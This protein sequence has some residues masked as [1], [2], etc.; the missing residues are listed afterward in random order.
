MAN[1]RDLR[2]RITSVGNIEK[3]T[4]AMEMVATTK[5]RRFQDKAV[6]AKPYTG[7]IEDLVRRLAGAV[8]ADPAA[9]GD[10]AP[11][12]AAGAAGTPRA[13]LFVGSDRGLCGAY[14]SNIQ[15]RLEEHLAGLEQPFTLYVIGRKAM[16]HAERCGHPVAAYLEDQPLEKVSFASAAAVSAV[17][18]GAFRAGEVSAVDLCF[19]RFLSMMRYEP[20]VEPFLPILAPAAAADAETILEPGGPEVLGRL[21]PKFLETAVYHA[22]LESITS[23]YASRR[24]AMSNATDAAGEMKKEITRTFNKVRQQKI[25][26]EILEIVSGAEAL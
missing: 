10:A 7:D 24:F 26:S 9:A 3:I 15:R 17:L 11:L 19:T 25:T 13:I 16:E 1:L 4:R 12:F 22:L 8:A 23:E 21:I 20:V 18:V 2:Q 6:A 5:L 14:N